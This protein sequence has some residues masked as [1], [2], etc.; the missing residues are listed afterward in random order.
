MLGT[1][2]AVAVIT[3]TPLAV[4]AQAESFEELNLRGALKPGDT[5]FV[6]TVDAGDLNQLTRGTFLSFSETTIR[7]ESEGVTIDLSEPI[8]RRID[9]RGDSNFNGILIGLGAGAAVGLTLVAS[10]DGFLCPS[11]ATDAAIFAGIGAALGLCVG[12]AVDALLDDA[13]RLASPLLRQSKRDQ[14]GPM[15]PIAD[16]DDD[17]LL[18]AM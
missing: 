15:K 7:L 9:R 10:C 8:V 3:L 16:R 13:Y 12:Y 18:A 11:G 6:G 17:V 5:I 2:A 1:A 14:L 4:A